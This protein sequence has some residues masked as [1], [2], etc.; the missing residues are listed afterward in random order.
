MAKEDAVE[1]ESALEEMERNLV[2]TVVPVTEVDVLSKCQMEFTWLVLGLGGVLYVEERSRLIWTD[3][4]D[5]GKGVGGFGTESSG[6]KCAD[7]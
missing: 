1:A 2:D 5:R 6:T 7:N 3:R 4:T